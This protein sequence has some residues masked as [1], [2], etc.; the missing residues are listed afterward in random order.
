MEVLF[1]YYEG[2]NQ[3]YSGNQGYVNNNQMG[4]NTNYT[5]N[6][7]TQP[8]TGWCWGAFM[9]N[10]IWGIAHKCYLPL[11]C[12]IPIFGLFWL[13]VCGAKGHSWAMN[14]GLFRTVEEYNASMSTWNRAGKFAL[15]FTIVFLILYF[16]LFGTILTGI[17]ASA[18]LS[19]Y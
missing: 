5:V 17:I 15:I 14:S 13:F 12:F 16:L 2:Q 6:Q 19:T 9:Y 18:G 11:L 1:M 8:I 3:N 7:G 10:W 4:V